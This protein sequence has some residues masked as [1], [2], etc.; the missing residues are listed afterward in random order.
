M[1]GVLTPNGSRYA[2][3]S[4][5]PSA[6]WGDRTRWCSPWRAAGPRQGPGNGKGTSRS[7][8]VR[9]RFGRKSRRCPRAAILGA[10]AGAATHRG[11]R[12]GVRRRPIA[13]AS[14]SNGWAALQAPDFLLALRKI[15]SAGRLSVSR[16]SGVNAH[17][18]CCMKPALQSDGINRIA[19][20][21]HRTLPDFRISRSKGRARRAAAARREFAE[22]IAPP[23]RRLLD[24]RF[25]AFHH[26]GARMG[27]S[28]GSASARAWSALRSPRR[29]ASCDARVRSFGRPRILAAVGLPDVEAVGRCKLGGGHDGHGWT[30]E[31]SSCALRAIV[32]IESQQGRSPPPR[33]VR[34]NPINLDLVGLNFFWDCGS[35]GSP[36]MLCR[37][38][39]ISADQA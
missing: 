8:N 21:C 19:G 38:V 2:R 32:I 6:P 31:R 11:T 13:T 10:P 25:M 9:S 33:G 34:Q 35:P 22:P 29:G 24:C 16:P 18:P 3:M 27:E 20:A 17:R 1:C 28:G 7:R 15:S 37:T 23:A 5:P 14:P 30:S 12:R 36:S 26:A 39:R 4:V